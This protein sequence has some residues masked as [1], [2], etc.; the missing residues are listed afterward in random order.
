MVITIAHLDLRRVHT[1][2]SISSKRLLT[3]FLDAQPKFIGV[4][5][6]ERAVSLEQISC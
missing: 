3:N 5:E 6:L 2:A 1:A 4:D